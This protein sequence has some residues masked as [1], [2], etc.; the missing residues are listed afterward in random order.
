[1]QG[2]GDV[3]YP[4]VISTGCQLSR[5]AVSGCPGGRRG[6]DQ[7]MHLFDNHAINSI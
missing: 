7:K 1:M 2:G 5:C 6:E 3:D 4:G